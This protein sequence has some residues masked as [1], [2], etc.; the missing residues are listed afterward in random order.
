M[1]DDFGVEYVGIKQ[2]KHLLWVLQSYHQVQINMAGNK[3]VGLN[4]QWDFPS[5]RVRINMRSYVKDLLQSLNH[6]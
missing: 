6:A 1:V 5:K 4:V 2:I 3:I